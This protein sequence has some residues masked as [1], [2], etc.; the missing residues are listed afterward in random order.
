MARQQARANRRPEPA[1][2]RDQ[3][4][5]APWR[6]AYLVRART[7]QPRCIFCLRRLGALQLSRRLV[8][9]AGPDALVMLN[10]YPYN[11]GH[12]MVAP[13]R[14]IASPELLSRVPIMTRAFRASSHAA[15]ALVGFG[16]KAI[17]VT[18][19]ESGKLA[20]VLPLHTRAAA[21][22][23]VVSP[24]ALW[25]LPAHY[26]NPRLMAVS[27]NEQHC[28]DLALV[29][30]SGTKILAKRALAQTTATVPIPEG[31]VEPVR[32]SVSALAP[33]G[34]E[35]RQHVYLA[36]PFATRGTAPQN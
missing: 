20:S 33:E 21:A 25:G 13:R 8:L 12:L 28:T 3:R 14:H 35:L 36:P 9:Y 19:D 22:Q 10:R 27:F 30:A 34:V 2:V 17:A 11:N 29:V 16:K 7:R 5:W 18:V 23:V 24:P 32:V 26:V 4:L 31:L 15:S 1:L 6:S